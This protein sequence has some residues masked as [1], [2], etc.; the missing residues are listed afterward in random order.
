[1]T[2]GVLLAKFGF[3]VGR[4]FAYINNLAKVRLPYYR[5][6]MGVKLKRIYTH[7]DW[8]KIIGNGESVLSHWSMAIIILTILGL[9]SA[10]LNLWK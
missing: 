8:R 9:I 2:R 10:G 5:D 4:L 1:V 7:V 6:A 3:G